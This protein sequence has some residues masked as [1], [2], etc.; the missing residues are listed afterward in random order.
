MTMMA[1][2]IPMIVAPILK[3]NT[4]SITSA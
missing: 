3:R 4:E 1:I 2:A